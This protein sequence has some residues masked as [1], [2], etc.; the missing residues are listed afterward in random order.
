MIAWI[1]EYLIEPHD[2]IKF[3]ELDGI[4]ASDQG[5]PSI[6]LNFGQSETMAIALRNVYSFYVCPPSPTVQ[7]S[8]VITSR[9]GDV[10]KPLWYSASEQN[11][12]SYQMDSATWPGYDIIDILS[13]FNPL[14]R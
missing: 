5:F 4:L 6:D 9:S 7:G 13:A 12:R 14:K 3:I 1:P 11:D 2:I 10:L 8:I